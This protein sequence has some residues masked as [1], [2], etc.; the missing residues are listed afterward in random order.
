MS[1][2]ISPLIL[3]DDCEVVSTYLTQSLIAAG[4]PVVRSFDLQRARGAHTGCAC[5]HHGEA[6]CNCQM[7]V[8]LVYLP[9]GEPH[10]L[11]IHGRDGVTHL[12]WD[13]TFPD[14]EESVLFAI[15]KDLFSQI[16][17]AQESKIPLSIH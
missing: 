17:D 12:E 2:S 14:D 13:E 3:P 11:L 5:P 15:I 9:N 6:Q 10:T 4:Y 1:Q 16:K 8:L 7:I